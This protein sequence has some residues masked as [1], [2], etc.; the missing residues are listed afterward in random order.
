ML[1][2]TEAV[3]LALAGGLGIAATKLFDFLL[4]RKKVDVE[5]ETMQLTA[6]DT[7]RASELG[8]IFEQYRAMNEMLRAEVKEGRAELVEC[9]AGREKLKVEVDVLQTEVRRLT[10][11]M[12]EREA[13]C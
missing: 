3:W 11:M 6:A 7:R 1:G 10:R 9:I 5:V 13:P 8:Y 4:A 2:F 12:D